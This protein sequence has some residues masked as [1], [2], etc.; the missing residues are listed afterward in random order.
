MSSDLCKIEYQKCPDGQVFDRE[1]GKCV[2]IKRGK[3]TRPTRG[4]WPVENIVKG[5]TLRS[6][7][8]KIVCSD[9]VFDN[10]K[11]DKGVDPIRNEFFN[12]YDLLYDWARGKHVSF[13]E[14]WPSHGC[15]VG[16]FYPLT[17]KN[18]QFDIK[19]T[20]NEK[21][22]SELYKKMPEN[23]E[24]TYIN[25]VLDVPF[26]EREIQANSVQSGRPNSTDPGY[27]G[28]DPRISTYKFEPKYNFY[29]QRY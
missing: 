19:G 8:L 24:F 14:T 18:F 20:E 25:F 17:K 12:H 13:H 9:L 5:R 2:P 15:V 27:V 6:K 29:Q 3:K 23:K 1:K 4:K 10:K 16:Q 7:H 21:L 26:N 11:S 22:A 28:A